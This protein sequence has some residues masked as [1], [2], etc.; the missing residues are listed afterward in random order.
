ME[1][2][3]FKII[4]S[5]PLPDKA[6]SP[7]IDR[8]VAASINTKEYSSPG[9]FI[10]SPIKTENAPFP[11]VIKEESHSS[12]C[13]DPMDQMNKS[14]EVDQEG[15]EQIVFE[16]F[17]PKKVSIDT[18]PLTWTNVIARMR[19]KTILLAPVYQRNEVWGIERKSQLIES[20]LL[21]IPIPMFYVAADE[22]GNYE[23]VDGLQRLSALRDF[24]FP[25]GNTDS[26]ESG[27]GFALEGLEFLDL[28][29]KKFND[30]DDFYIQRL[31][32]TQFMFTVIGPGTPEEVKFHIFS[33]I[34]RGGL[35]L[36]D[37]EVRHALYNGPASY[38]LQELADSQ[39][40][41]AVAANTFSRDTMEDREVILRM[42]A[43]MLRPPREFPGKGKKMGDFLSETMLIINAMPSFELPRFRKKFN[44]E[45]ISTFNFTELSALKDRFKLGLKRAYDLF[46]E[47]AFRKSIPGNRRSRLNKALFDTWGSILARMDDIAYEKLTD[48]VLEF[49]DEYATLLNDNSFSRAISNNAL[50]R[51][52]INNRFDKLTKIARKW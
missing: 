24:V 34:N 11:P 27:N 30:L 52:F 42:L 17:D 20:L 48:S 39:E 10:S 22:M 45:D 41:H 3:N 2:K 28:N 23:V 50:E 9:K 33:R 14:D 44:S 15:R 26:K 29:G 36:S 49:F 43:F 21:N 19:K 51:D 25:N 8:S 40:F 31:E 35:T 1:R 7:K 38:L 47:H 12:A 5:I 13:A 46:G 37:Q 18:R 6:A 4:S 16:P 32:E